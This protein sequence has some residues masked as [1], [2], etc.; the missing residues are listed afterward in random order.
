MPRFFFDVIDHEIATDEDGLDLPSSAAAIE[1]AHRSA[2]SLAAET[3]LR[4]NLN[5]QHRI[6]VRDEQGTVAEV[7][8]RQAIALEG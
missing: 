6:I 2:R 7:L 4:G 1:E 3:V 8:L 5:L